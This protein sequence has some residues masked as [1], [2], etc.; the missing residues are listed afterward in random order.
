MGRPLEKA[1]APG[2]YRRPPQALP[3]TPGTDF[4]DR[5]DF[6]LGRITKKVL[7]SAMRR[8]KRTVGIGVMG[9][10]F[11]P[12]IRGSIFFSKDVKIQIDEMDDHRFVISSS[13]RYIVRMC[14]GVCVHMSSYVF[15]MLIYNLHVGWFVVSN[16]HLV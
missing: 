4:V 5:P 8:D 16:F 9:R 10:F 2:W 7:D 6:G 15:L 12:S 11:R 13:L 3:S 14:V 1:P